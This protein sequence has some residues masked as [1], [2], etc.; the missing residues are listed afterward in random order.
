MDED[1][2]KGRKVESMKV[3]DTLG[4]SGAQVVP[5]ARPTVQNLADAAR[6]VSV[7]LSDLD[8]PQFGGART[9][10]TGARCAGTVDISKK[11]DAPRQR[12]GGPVEVERAPTEK[13][14]EGA[15]PERAAG[16]GTSTT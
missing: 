3:K 13:T 6:G 2:K 4:A 8:G 1:P 16:P 7:S 15:A 9:V 12:E 14:G 5:T 11:G 10:E